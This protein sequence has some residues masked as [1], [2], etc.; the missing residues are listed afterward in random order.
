LPTIVIVIQT[1]VTLQCL[2]F[3]RAQLPPLPP[4]EISPHE[5]KHPREPPPPYHGLFILS[6][7]TSCFAALCFTIAD[8]LETRLSLQ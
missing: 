2:L 8:Y 5:Q 7:D 1:V 4:P 3:V 6:V